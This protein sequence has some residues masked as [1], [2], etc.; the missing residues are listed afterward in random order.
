MKNGEKKKNR[1]KDIHCLAMKRVLSISCHVWQ[2]FAV[3]YVDKKKNIQ[4]GLVHVVHV[5]NMSFTALYPPLIFL[6]MAYQSR[7]VE[8]VSLLHFFFF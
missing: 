1:K 2:S 6:A 7:T 3:L 5:V 4:A 8:F